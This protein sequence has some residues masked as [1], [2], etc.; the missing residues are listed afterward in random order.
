MLPNFTGGYPVSPQAGQQCPWFP[1][2][3]CTPNCQGNFCDSQPNELLK[4]FVT[5]PE[6][7][8]GE[9]L[10]DA[11]PV[12]EDRPP[13]IDDDVVRKIRERYAPV[14]PAPEN[15]KLHPGVNATMRDDLRRA[16]SLAKEA[17]SLI[18]GERNQDYGDALDDFTRT[19]KMW[20][21]ILGLPEVTPE[22]VAL[23]M[24]ILKVRRITVSPGKRDHWVDII[25]YAALGGEIAL[26]DE[27]I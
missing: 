2:S 19:G 14:E 10:L 8:P 18:T 20:A 5:N 12:I 15:A 6:E 1:A 26:R 9:Q 22:Q 4:P 7:V 13:D 25:G 16:E 11:S 27:K 17:I 3:V 21:P 24:I 23:C